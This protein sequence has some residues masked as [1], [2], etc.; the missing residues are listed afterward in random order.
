MNIRN[1]SS[2]LAVVLAALLLATGAAP[3]LRVTHAWAASPV[4]EQAQKLYD[5]A[6]FADAVA[7]LREAVGS[8]KVVGQDALSARALLARCLVK[9]GNRLDAKKEFAGVLKLNPNWKPNPDVV[10][11]DEMDVFNLASR[12]FVA[13]Q[14]REGQR[15]PA[16]I[17]ANL[18]LLSSGRSDAKDL[19]SKHGGKKLENG[20]QFGGA[21]RFPINDRWSLDIGITHLG[22]KGT[23]IYTPGP[24]T[25]E[26]E[27]R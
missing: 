17:T 5:T 1:R 9:A 3:G 14:I 2:A 10:P 16:S 20:V 26:L 11:P 23:L 13:E 24:D 8:G 19:L 15:I 6:K 25:L 27:T 7:Q 18:G 22:D 4:V 21:V 12:E